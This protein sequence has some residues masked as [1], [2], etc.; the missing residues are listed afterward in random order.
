MD[1]GLT[2]LI[3]RRDG[4][5]RNVMRE[6]YRISLVDGKAWDVTSGR[7]VTFDTSPWA[8]DCFPDLVKAGQNG[9]RRTARTVSFRYVPLLPV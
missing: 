6:F 4:F 5:M 1:T 8:G 3:E 9:A 2:G 7:A